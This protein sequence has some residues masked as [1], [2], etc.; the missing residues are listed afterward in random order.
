MLRPTPARVLYLLIGAVIGVIGLSI[1]GSLAGPLPFL[2][3][4]VPGAR[5][6]AP[7]VTVAP[8]VFSGRTLVKVVPVN[9]AATKGTVQVRINTLEEYSDG[10][11]LTYSIISGQ[12]GEPAPVLQP[13]RFALTDDRGGSYS[14]SPL[15]STATSGPGLSAGYLSFSPAI[16]PEVRTL[17]V[18]VPHLLILSEVGE[19][20]QP[21]VLDGPWQVHV[22]VR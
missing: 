9:Q 19:G 12:E 8:R 11:S 14:L 16:G 15:G 1:Y 22:P 7:G 20:G 3:P 6:G 5:G 17:T 18:T 4:L 21:R 10:F 2:A 13:E